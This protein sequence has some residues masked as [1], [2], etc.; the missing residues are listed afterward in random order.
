LG[1]RNHGGSPLA[2]VAPLAVLRAA[3]DQRDD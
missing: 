2:P 3:D 1:R